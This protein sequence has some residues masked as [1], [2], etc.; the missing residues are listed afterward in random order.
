MILPS[1]YRTVFPLLVYLYFTYSDLGGCLSHLC[2][3][4]SKYLYIYLYI[5]IYIYIYIYLFIYIYIYIFIYI[6]IYTISLILSIHIIKLYHTPPHPTPTVI[7]WYTCTCFTAVYTYL[8]LIIFQDAGCR[9][10]DAYK[11]EGLLG[12]C[13]F[14]FKVNI[15]C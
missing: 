2:I 12:I 4:I 14:I 5:Y 7:N 13:H 11:A 10:V 8:F 1:K 6:F 3:Y 15:Q 9:A